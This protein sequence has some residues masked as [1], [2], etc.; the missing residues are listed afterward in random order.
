MFVRSG[1][2]V[3]IGKTIGLAGSTGLATGPHLDFRI[4][5]RGQYKNF[6]RLG[7]PP[8]VPVSKKNWADFKAVCEKWLPLLATL[9]NPELLQASAAGASE[10][11]GH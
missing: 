11:S 2:H 1:E 5:Q 7:L 10:D 8:L 3:E 9:E 6:E 4:L